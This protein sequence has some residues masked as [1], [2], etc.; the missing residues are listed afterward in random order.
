[1]TCLKKLIKIMNFVKTSSLNT[2]LY[3]RL[4]SDR[5]CFLFHSKVRWLSRGNGAIRVFEHRDKLPRFFKEKN[6]DLKDFL[7]KNKFI[8]RLALL[9][10]IFQVF[11]FL[12]PYSR[13]EFK[14]ETEQNSC[15]SKPESI[16]LQ[17]RNLDYKRG[18][19]TVS[20]VQLSYHSFN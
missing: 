6:L 14:P 9:S 17:T 5:K 4:G 19:Q 3:S 11:N 12:N 15:Y 20:Y 13:I 18:E 10:D 7:E 2:W 1:M 16:H 8:S